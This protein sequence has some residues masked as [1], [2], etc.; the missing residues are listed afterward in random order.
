MPLMHEPTTEA[1]VL[2]LFG[3]MAQKLG[4]IMVHAQTEFPEEG[5]CQDCQN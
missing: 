5:D 2:F 4:M 3:M 1:C